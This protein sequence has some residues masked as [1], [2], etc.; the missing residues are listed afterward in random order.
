[1]LAYSVGRALCSLKE[2]IL[3]RILKMETEAI[4]ETVVACVNSDDGKFT[5]CQANVKTL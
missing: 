1:M 3:F 4:S 2:Y 5:T